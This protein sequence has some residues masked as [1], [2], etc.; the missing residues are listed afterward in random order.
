VAVTAVLPPPVTPALPS[1]TPAVTS[2]PPPELRQYR[3][4]YPAAVAAVAAAAEP[5]PEVD[6]EDADYLAD[7]PAVAALQVA[8]APPPPPPPP[9]PAAA[10]AAEADP[11]RLFQALLSELEQHATGAALVPLCK[12]LRPVSI[13]GSVFQVAYDPEE[14][15]ADEIRRVQAPETM[16]VVRECFA[17]VAPTPES[18]IVVKRWIA[19]VSGD[20]RGVRRRPSSEERTRVEN[21]PFVR[22]VCAAVGGQVVDV[23]VPGPEPR[24]GER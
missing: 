21:L 8:E 6:Q 20:Q 15:A 17:R 23:R 19:S 16:K 14:L 2:A 13:I 5:P 18:A 11:A 1:E 22:E 24:R 7:P 12:R 4:G 3:D 10:P 9:P